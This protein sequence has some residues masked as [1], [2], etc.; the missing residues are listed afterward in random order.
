LAGLNLGKACIRYR[1][2]EQVDWNVV[3]SL[4]ADLCDS[5]DENRYKG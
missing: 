3:S 5:P 2:P 4:L 1:R